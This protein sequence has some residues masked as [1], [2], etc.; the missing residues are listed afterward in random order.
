MSTN[1]I[2]QALFNIAVSAGKHAMKH[3]VKEA[4]K[5]QKASHNSVITGGGPAMAKFLQL[6]SR[7][8]YQT[9]VDAAAACMQDLRPGALDETETEF[10]RMWRQQAR[11]V[12][13]SWTELAGFPDAATSKRPD[14]DS[15]SRKHS[16]A[17]AS[18]RDPRMELAKG[19]AGS[20]SVLYVLMSSSTSMPPSWPA[21]CVAFGLLGSLWRIGILEMRGTKWALVGEEPSAA[22]CLPLTSPVVRA[23]RQPLSEP[24]LAAVAAVTP[25]FL[26]LQQASRQA[27]KHEAA[28]AFALPTASAA[29]AAVMYS[30][31]PEAASCK[32]REQSELRR[33]ALSA[34]AKLL[35][36]GSSADQIYKDWAQEGT[37]RF[38]SPTHAAAVLASLPQD[39]LLAV[40]HEFLAAFE[41][42]KFEQLRLASVEEATRILEKECAAG[43]A[44][45]GAATK[46]GTGASRAAAAASTAKAAID[47]TKATMKTV[48]SAAAAA[49][50]SGSGKAAAAAAAANAA[51]KGAPTH[52]PFASR[53]GW[54]LVG[55][56]FRAPVVGF[57]RAAGTKMA[58]SSAFGKV[59]GG[60]IV[61][62]CAFAELDS[63]YFNPADPNAPRPDVPLEPT[64]LPRVQLLRERYVP[65]PSSWR[66]ASLAD[67]LSAGPHADTSCRRVAVDEPVRLAIERAMHGT[68]HTTCLGIDGTGNTRRAKV[69]S[70]ERVENLPLWKQYWHKK[71]EL[72]DTHHANNVHVKPLNP[73]VVHSGKGKGGAGLLDADGLLEP[74][75]NEVYLFHGT[76]S[77]VADII[78]CH[79]FDERVA[80]VSGLYGAGVYFANQSCKAAQ[81]AQDS[82][83]KTLIV[84]RVTLGDAYYATS[85]LSQHRRPPE[86]DTR[87]G[88][89][90]G[91]TYDC[92]VANTGGS[93]AH[94]ELIVYDHRQAYPEYVVRFRPG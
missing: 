57:A 60:L 64:P 14:W 42:A 85:N 55:S 68:A 46:V 86:R 73:P 63:E 61:A 75:L 5:A 62:I 31:A 44:G 33:K 16:D 15:G 12:D 32:K 23:L 94:R 8:K 27:S 83:V 69:L 71:H 92:V 47:P 87:I 24:E 38:G 43:A 25:R 88:W 93:Q 81:Y 52:S 1:P 67:K 74:G 54:L 49:A 59:I 29:L 51:A 9:H 76:T 82:G 2:G 30:T 3:A 50:A 22:P 70:V 40:E 84:A 35:G 72:V 11:I 6:R 19:W 17:D 18:F 13:L 78:T 65:I 28:D 56:I 89:K 53:V 58:A 48:G 41:K 77:E 34:H 79:G 26:A 45:A 90:P 21:S 80:N 10:L 20:S 36:A 91:L 4:M 7:K 37:Y 39:R 66:A